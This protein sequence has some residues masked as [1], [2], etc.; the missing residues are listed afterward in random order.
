MAL[1]AAITNE[2]VE[3][4][5]AA[6]LFV[7]LHSGEPNSE[8]SNETDAGRQE[9]NWGT[10]SEGSVSAASV[11]FTGGDPGG[12]VTHVGLWSEDSG[13]DFLGWAELSPGSDDSFNSAGNFVLTDLTLSSEAE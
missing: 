1:N 4:M 2:A 13:G 9:I 7:S 10:P 12:D 3:A 5:S 8:G 6:A 11:S